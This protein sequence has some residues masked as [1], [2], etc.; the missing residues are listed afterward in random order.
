MS[1]DNERFACEQIS[2][3]SR[4]LNIDLSE[5]IESSKLTVPKSFIGQWARG[6]SD[7]LVNIDDQH[8]PE[9]EDWIKKAIEA[10]DGNGMRWGLGQDYAQ[11]ARMLERKGELSN[12]R[13]MMTKA[14]AIMKECGADGWA[15]RCEEE[16]ARL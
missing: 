12:A 7:L 4:V 6:V 11:Y 2:S 16:L 10:D 3:R 8:L 15:A 1:F 9:A 5:V 13:E 14:I